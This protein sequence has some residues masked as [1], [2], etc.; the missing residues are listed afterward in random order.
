M[1]THVTV[2]S[3]YLGDLKNEN[4]I[5]NVL[6]SNTGYIT[7]SR[8]HVSILWLFYFVA[9]MPVFYYNEKSMD[10]FFLIS[11]FILCALYV[12]VGKTLQVYFNNGDFW[13]WAPQ[14]D[15]L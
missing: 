10:N 2:S 14:F 1:Q 15:S 13:K 5:M 9:K 7:K 3:L 6:N 12:L 8:Q 4:S 11:L